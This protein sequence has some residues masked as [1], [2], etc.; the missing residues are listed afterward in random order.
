[1]TQSG[2][3]EVPGGRLYWEANGS[4]HPLL[5][6]HGNLGNLRMWD[7]HVDSFAESYRVI[8]YDRR[9]FGRSETEQVAFSDRADA[10]AVLAQGLP[11]AASCHV[12]GQ[13]MGGTIALDLAIEAPKAVDSLTLVNGGASGLE[14][15]LPD[16]VLP[17]PFE[18][19]GSLWESKAWIPLAD[20]ETR[21]WVDGWGQP[22]TRI[23]PELRRRVHDE[24]LSTY[25]AENREGSPQALT[26]LAA[27]R[28]N[29]V[30]APTLVLIGTLDEPGG[31]I[32]GRHVADVVG[33]ARLVEF[34]DAAHMP[35]LEEP[36]RFVRVTMEFLAGVD[37][38]RRPDSYQSAVRSAS[39]LTR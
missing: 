30:R 9:G 3:V 14:A 12:I 32:N 10:L 31:V 4:G 29:E 18:E 22:P 27:S 19:M 6:I 24:I 1:M 5:L 39:G 34:T 23:D 37:A 11:G 26:P 7:S 25:Q 38:G 33:G 2:F 8:R 36:E 15:E 20:L 17:P 13:S 21:V 28:L 16:D 35:H